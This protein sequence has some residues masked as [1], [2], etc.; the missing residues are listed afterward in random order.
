M[1][2]ILLISAIMAFTASFTFSETASAEEDLSY[3]ERQK[4]RD[5][6]YNN[7]FDDG[8]DEPSLFYEREEAK[9]DRVRSDSYTKP[10]VEL[11]NGLSNKRRSSESVMSDMMTKR[12]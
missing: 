5:K 3:W 9:E 8:D 6:E 7:P 12:R 11:R 10:T 4:Q 2:K 1:K